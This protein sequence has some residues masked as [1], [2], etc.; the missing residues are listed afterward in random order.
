MRWMF[1]L[2]DHGEFAIGIFYLDDN[3]QKETL[4]PIVK[5]NVY[6]NAIKVNNN[7]DEDDI[8]FPT[9]IYLDCLQ[10]CQENDFNPMGFILYKINHS[11]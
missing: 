6:T 7:V 1:G 5:N 4:M 2:V 11:L 8:N 3:R 10:S 9:H